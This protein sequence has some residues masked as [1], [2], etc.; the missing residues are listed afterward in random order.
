MFI[1]KTNYTPYF[2]DNKLYSQNETFHKI[3]NLN[4]SDWL[5]NY[6]ISLLDH[7]EN[8]NA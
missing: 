7:K 3:K 2:D 5:S 6:T 1:V 8:V 4:T